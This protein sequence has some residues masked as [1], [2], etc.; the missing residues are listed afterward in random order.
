VLGVD[1]A[2][3]YRTH[4]FTVEI[5]SAIIFFTDGVVEVDRD[6][7]SGLRQLRD[8]VE[9]EYRNA[10]GNIA[11]AILGRIFL[12]R[13]PR[14]DV[15]LL[16]LGITALDASPKD[17]RVVWQ[18]DGSDEHSARRVKRA[19]LWQLGE[20]R[21]GVDLNAAEL[22]VNELMGNVAR[23]APGPANLVLEW[24]NSSAVVSVRD[25]GAQFE[26]PAQNLVEPFSENGRGLYLVK[27]VAQE[28]RV[29]WTGDGNRV[30][31]VLPLNAPPD[32]PEQR[33]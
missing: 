29:E 21:S 9:A 18:F 32:H 17:T 28:V 16:F 14:D 33:V 25:R 11:E 4:E 12:R 27:T 22:V 1:S 13:L 5:G 3:E 26:L 2:A 30:S 19:V 31:A 20:A 8:A 10:S 23:H 15:A 6:Y 24:S 7:V